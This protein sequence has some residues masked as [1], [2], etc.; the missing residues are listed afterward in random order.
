MYQMCRRGA[1]N[2]PNF[3]GIG[4][5]FVISLV[6]NVVG[7]SPPSFPFF[8]LFFS[9]FLVC[10]SPQ[11]SLL[12]FIRSTHSHTLNHHHS[13]KAPRHHPLPAAHHWPP[14]RRPKCLPTASAW[15]TNNFNCLSKFVSSPFTNISLNV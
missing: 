13:T 4:A 1:W 9:F 7:S 10:W 6:S 15:P 11:L 12:L 2:F 14:L 5:W 8:V 3:S